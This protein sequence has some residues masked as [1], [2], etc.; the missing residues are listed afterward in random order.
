MPKLEYKLQDVEEIASNILTQF[1]S[2]II[3]F[4]GQMGT[5]KTTLI[6][7]L[8]KASGGIDNGN[9]PTFG[10]VNEYH[11]AEGELLAHHFDFYRINGEEEALDLGIEEYFDADAYVFIEWP[12]KIPSLLPADHNKVFLYFIDENTRRIEY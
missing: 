2:N 11:T 12:E 6:K 8:V 1:N 4:Y 10:L 5:G 9:S 7:A 3:C